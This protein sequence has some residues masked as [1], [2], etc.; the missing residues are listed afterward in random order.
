MKQE[1]QRLRDEI[2]YLLNHQKIDKSNY[3]LITSNWLGVISITISV[4]IGLSAIII[5]LSIKDDTLSQLRLT[6]L[7]ITL[8]ILL[9]LVKRRFEE[10]KNGRKEYSKNIVSTEEK[11]EERY[12]KIHGLEKG[13]FKEKLNDEFNKITT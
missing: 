12:A 11:N 10:F 6:I 5:P 1:E 13:K 8:L 7:L 9:C 4:I 2:N 3:D